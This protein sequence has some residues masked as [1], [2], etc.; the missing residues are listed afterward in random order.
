VRISGTGY[1]A[2]ENG[3]II[4]LRQRT[5][6]TLEGRVDGRRIE[7]LF[8]ELGPGG[9]NGGTWV[10]RQT[11]TGSLRG[12]FWNDEGGQSRGSAHAVRVAPA[13]PPTRKH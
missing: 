5:P 7:L 11:D 2:M 8:T 6:I 13:S 10:L 4:P 12:T 9:T 1:R 3:H